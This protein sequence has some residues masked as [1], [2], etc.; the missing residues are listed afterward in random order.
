MKDAV[1]IIVEYCLAIK[2]SE[3]VLIIVDKKSSEI[4]KA[5]F[6]AVKRLGAET[7][8]LEMVEREAHGSDPPRV[9]AEA[10]KRADVVIAP[11]SKK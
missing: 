9:V 5:L 6:K 4:G 11:T 1:R 7:V 10:M 8:L 3:E 2:K